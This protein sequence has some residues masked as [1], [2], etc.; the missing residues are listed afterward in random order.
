MNQSNES[1]D[2]EAQVSPAE[3]IIEVPGRRSFL[4]GAFTQGAALTAM[5]AVGA[6]AAGAT[7]VARPEVLQSIDIKELA[8]LATELQGLADDIASTL[9]PDLANSFSAEEIAL[10][11]NSSRGTLQFTCGNYTCTGNFTCSDYSC[12]GRFKVRL[13]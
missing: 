11:T 6:Q 8:K 5:A 9:L 12:T 2:K 7:P 4:L 10:I 1:L 13:Q 3:A